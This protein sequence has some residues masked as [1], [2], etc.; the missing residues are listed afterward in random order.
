MKLSTASKNNCIQLKVFNIRQ[1]FR[2]IF[3]F[4]K[5]NILY[6]LILKFPEE[7]ILLLSGLGP[8]S[9]LASLEPS[10]RQTSRDFLDSGKSF[11]V[12]N[13]NLAA[14]ESRV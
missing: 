6:F 2:R 11:Y 10:S 7:E 13:Q 5:I 12:E 4:F 8:I 3:S 9:G 14:L 1:I